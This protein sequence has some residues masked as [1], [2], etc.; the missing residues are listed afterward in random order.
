MAI[1]SVLLILKFY[2]KVPSSLSVV[3]NTLLGS[4]S[5]TTWSVIMREPMALVVDEDGDFYNVWNGPPAADPC[6]T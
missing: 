3:C 6:Q 2:K 4:L 5:L 1:V